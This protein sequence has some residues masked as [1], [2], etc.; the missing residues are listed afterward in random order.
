MGKLLET[1]LLTLIPNRRVPLIWGW[2]RE[3]FGSALSRVIRT[4]RK[5]SECKGRQNSFQHTSG[6]FDV[7]DL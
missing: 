2:V 1:A 6:L 4:P 7:W 3:L 5:R